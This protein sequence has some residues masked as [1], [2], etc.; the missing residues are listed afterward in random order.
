MPLS[1][2]DVICLERHDFLYIDP[3]CHPQGAI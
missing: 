1:A 3:K 2:L